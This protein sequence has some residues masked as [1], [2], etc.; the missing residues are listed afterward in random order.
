MVMTKNPKAKTF[1]SVLPWDDDFMTL[2]QC[3]EGYLITLVGDID[4]S[5]LWG[6]GVSTFQVEVDEVSV[7][8]IEGHAVDAGRLY[9]VD[10]DVST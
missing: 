2:C 1:L 5:L 6:L 3:L 9:H 7:V 4:M 10:V 8:S